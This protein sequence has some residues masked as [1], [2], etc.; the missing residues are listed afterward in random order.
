MSSSPKDS[1]TARLKKRSDW[2]RKRRRWFE[3][4]DASGVKRL[5]LLRSQAECFKLMSG[6]R[7]IQPLN[8][9]ALG[10]Y[11]HP[12]PPLKREVREH[13]ADHLLP[14]VRV[15]CASLGARPRSPLNS[16]TSFLSP[17]F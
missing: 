3:V 1:L 2:L 14:V 15:L 10:R 5:R 11:R 7:S 12:L 16:Q 9:L 13:M 17:R 4:T 8:D 6:S